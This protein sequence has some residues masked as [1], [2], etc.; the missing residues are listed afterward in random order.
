METQTLTLGKRRFI[1]VPERDFRRLQKQASES[2]VRSEFAE[3]AMRE[4]RAY[5]KTRKA[6]EWNDIKRK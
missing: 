5:R 1:V 3:E 6:A 2:A 4:L